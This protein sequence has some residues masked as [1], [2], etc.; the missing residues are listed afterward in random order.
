[1]RTSKTKIFQLFW[2][3]YIK[4]IC[5]AAAARSTS[6]FHSLKRERNQIDKPHKNQ[7]EEK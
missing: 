6:M 5:M 4:K 7:E 1:M 3:M 2:A